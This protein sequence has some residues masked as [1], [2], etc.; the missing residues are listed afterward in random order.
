MCLFKRPVPA[1]PPPAAAAG[2]VRARALAPGAQGATPSVAASPAGP[3]WLRRFPAAQRALRGRPP[4]VPR[5]RAEQR[6]SGSPGGFA[7]RS[8][9]SLAIGIDVAA[10]RGCPLQ[11]AAAAAAC[12][13]A[14]RA[15]CC[16]RPLAGS[17]CW[18]RSVLRCRLP[19]MV[20]ICLPSLGGQGGGNW[21][22][23][24]LLPLVHCHDRR[25]SSSATPL[26]AFPQQA[27]AP[28]WLQQ[29]R[30]R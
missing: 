27:A 5:R 30:P 4:G 19:A 13:P 2:A 14:T 24:A 8:R 10:Q 26:A 7:A 6:R 16:I 9:R 28:R 21:G 17:G 18:L 29:L 11:A 23:A 3:S 1:V 25:R 12:Q 22:L 20:R 15:N